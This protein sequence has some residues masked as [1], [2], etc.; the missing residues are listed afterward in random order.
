VRTLYE[1]GNI[2][3]LILG[4]IEVRWNKFGEINTAGGN[5]FIFYWRG[6]E[7]TSIRKE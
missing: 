5:T 3:Q 4:V 7:M 2:Q 6:G 1:N